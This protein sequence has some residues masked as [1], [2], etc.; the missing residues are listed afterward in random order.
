MATIERTTESID[1]KADIRA[2]AN[3]GNASG[4]TP[5][6][7]VQ[8]AF[9]RE[10][11]IKVSRILRAAAEEAIETEAS[12]CSS[13]PSS[14]AHKLE[15]AELRASRK[16]CKG[17]MTPFVRDRVAALEKTIDDIAEKVYSA[18]VKF[19]ERSPFIVIDLGAEGVFRVKRVASAIAMVLSRIERKS[20]RPDGVYGGPL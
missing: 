11:R 9:S 5:A 13:W 3:Y 1:I 10:S 15:L 20:D 17:R 16:G 14:I 4:V 12:A 2:D 8:S 18:R 19:I 7:S 6:G